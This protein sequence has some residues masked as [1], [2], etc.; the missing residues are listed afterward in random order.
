MHALV[1][2]NPARVHQLAGCTCIEL[3]RR[4]FEEGRK[5]EE[6]DGGGR[7]TSKGKGEGE[8]HVLILVNE[9]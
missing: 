8:C 2:D 1:S 3:E 7:K 5:K 4:C 9:S 6:G